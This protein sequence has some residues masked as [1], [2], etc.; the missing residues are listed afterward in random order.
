MIVSVQVIDAAFGMPAA[1]VEVRFRQG[2]SAEWRELALVRTGADGRVELWRGHTLRPGRYQL[3][4]DLDGF[5]AATG[6]V[7]FYPRAIF[8][9]RLS[10]GAEDLHLPLV[11]SP[12]S[13]LAY[14]GWAPPLLR[15]PL[16]ADGVA[17]SGVL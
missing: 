9:L 14:R 10:G 13:V 7:A 17:A 5:Y 8:E 6:S 1:D 4:C 2:E 15:I 3:E 11:I 16:A 12:N